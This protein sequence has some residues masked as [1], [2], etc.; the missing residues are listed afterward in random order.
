MRSIWQAAFLMSGA[1]LTAGGMLA[2]AEPP[3]EVSGAV[4]MA[5]RLVRHHPYL[6]DAPTLSKLDEC[7]RQMRETA[8]RIEKL[9]GSA[10]VRAQEEFAGL[11]ARLPAILEKAYGLIRVSVEEGRATVAPPGPIALPGDAGGLLL[12]IDAG[13]GPERCV[14]PDFVDLTRTGERVAFDIASPG[15]TWAILSLMHMPADRTWLIVELRC[16]GGRSIRV[17][18]EVKS[19]PHGRLKVTILSA[20]TGQPA[21]AMVRL[22]W[23]YDNVDRV[24][25]NAIEF[26]PQ[27]D[28]QGHASGWRAANLPGRLGGHWWCVPGPFDMVVPPGEWEIAVRR[29]VEHVPLFETVRVDP[30]QTVEKALQPRRWVDMRKLGWWSGD[31]HVHCQILSE[32]DA[33]RLMAWVQAEDIHVANVLKMGDIYR[34]YFEQRGFGKEYRVVSGDTV[35]VPG[36]ECPRTHDQIGH[37]ISM[38]L[39]SMVRDTDRYYLYDLVF[40]AVYKQGGVSGYAHINSGIF[41]VHRDMTLNVPRGKACFGEI[42]QFTQLGTDLYYDFLNLGFKLTASAGSDVPWGGTIGEVRCYAYLGRT[43]FSADAW[44]DAF[45]RGR[46]F[47]TNGPMIELR[48]NDALPGDQIDAAREGRLHVTA[49]TWGDPDHVMPAKLEVIRHGEVVRAVEPSNPGQRELTIE[50]E[51]EAGD[52]CWIAARADSTDGRR[53]HTTPVYVV[54]QGKRF[55]KRDAVDELIARRLESLRQ[56]EDIVAEA[57]RQVQNAGR[58]VDR[59]TSELGRQGPELLERVAAARRLYEDLRAEAARE[60]QGQAR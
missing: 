10:K 8:Q 14:T 47:V 48:V 29:G 19:P 24:P 17:P 36:Q 55:W 40:D 59:P 41:H 52:G 26:A 44:F 13:P 43:P 27:F 38:N 35:L 11:T 1:V 32:D 54:R 45:R 37:T 31:D 56:I 9:S 15:T 22:V 21:P 51:T 4:E 49:R 33:Q 2:G 30:G 50:W 5:G 12:R 46:T 6:F 42:L 39:T 18:L 34:T 3:R 53:A 58:P 60:R 57:R 16:A 7:N 23:K 28:S 25:S 20:D